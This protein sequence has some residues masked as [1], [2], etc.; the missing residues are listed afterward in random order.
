MTGQSH[1]RLLHR[2]CSRRSCLKMKVPG[3]LDGVV[4]IA[5]HAD[6]L[7]NGPRGEAWPVRTR[8]ENVFFFFF[9]FFSIQVQGHPPAVAPRWCEMRASG[10]LRDVVD[11]CPGAERDRSL[12][13]EAALERSAGAERPCAIDEE[14]ANDIC[15][16]AGRQR[17]AHLPEDVSGLGAVD[18]KKRHTCAEGGGGLN[19]EDEGGVRVAFAVDSYVEAGRHDDGGADVV[20]A[21]EHDTG[22]DVHRRHAASRPGAVL[23]GRL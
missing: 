15:A 21:R 2:N 3:A 6:A 23:I 10:S 11:D 9:F 5:A 16:G 12:R 22:E 4:R 19:D 8:Q 20:R 17:P 7:W 1:I 18:R 13:E 14:G